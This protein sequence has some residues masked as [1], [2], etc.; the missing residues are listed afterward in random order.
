[1]VPE[2][3]NT[4]NPKEKSYLCQTPE[5]NNEFPTQFY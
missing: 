2:F 5:N 4:R 1:M 3:I